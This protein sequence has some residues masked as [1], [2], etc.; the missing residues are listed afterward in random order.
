M[1]KI[2]FTELKKK[3]QKYFNENMNFMFEK[4]DEISYALPVDNNW[5]IDLCIFRGALNDHNVIWR[6]KITSKWKG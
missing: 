4:T 6:R 3:L 2:F 5:Q 1:Q